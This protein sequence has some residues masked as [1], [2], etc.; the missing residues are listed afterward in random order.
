MM[1]VNLLR[2]SGPL[3]KVLLAHVSNPLHVEIRVKISAAVTS[4]ENSL[5]FDSHLHAAH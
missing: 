4:F 5:S 1:M 2:L 3:H